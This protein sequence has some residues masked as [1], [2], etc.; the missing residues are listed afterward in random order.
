MAE[1]SAH[2]PCSECG[3]CD[4]CTQEGIERGARLM[5]A[6]DEAKA[7]L[8]HLAGPSRR[9]EFAAVALGRVEALDGGVMEG[10]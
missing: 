5:A 10:R 2:Q 3:Y 1:H 7:A 9:I 4:L 8:A 6:L